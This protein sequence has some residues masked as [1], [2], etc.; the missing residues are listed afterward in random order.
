MLERLE[1]AQGEST[2][3][4]AQAGSTAGEGA[5]AAQAGAGGPPA[6]W[7]EKVRR[8][9]P[10]LLR[11]VPPPGTAVS[12][13]KAQRAGPRP[14]LPSAPPPVPVV[15]TEAGR[16]AR[17]SAA[18]EPA[19]P[20]ADAPPAARRPETPAPRLLPASPLQ[21]AGESA[22]GSP[23]PGI[24][25][26]VAPVTTHRIHL[27]PL[28]PQAPWPEPAPLHPVPSP[29]ERRDRWPALPPTA[30]PDPV[31]EAR[32]IWREQERRR[33]LAEEQEGIYGPRRV[34]HRG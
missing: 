14:A 6:H 8:G 34:S 18:G 27:K 22:K 28:P 19:L 32:A 29:T 31:E 25:E 30:E 2:P 1:R 13:A 26:Q 3:G 4:P 17:E 12:G 21:T 5:G 11:P 9:A 23:W 10:Y 7:V 24:A 16:V 33:Y 20:V 15:S